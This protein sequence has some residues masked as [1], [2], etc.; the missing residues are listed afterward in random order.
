MSNLALSLSGFF[1]L[2]SYYKLAITT[3]FVNKLWGK[4]N[5]ILKNIY[6]LSIFISSIPFI[7]TVYYINTQNI[8]QNIKQ[9]IFNGL[10]GIVLFS[11]FWMPLCILFLIKNNGKC[12]IRQIIILTLFLVSFCS[13]YV[14]YQLNNINDNTLLYNLTF[15]GMCYFFFH[16]FILDFITWSYHFFVK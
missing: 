7:L 5:G 13:F 12:I 11:I 6:I 8:N 1:L 14:L 15:Y 9:N 4:I 3:P 10:L 16:V 2:Y